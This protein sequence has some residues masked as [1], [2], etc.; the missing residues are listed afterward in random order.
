M[1]DRIY[2][3]TSHGRNKDGK[4]RPNRYAFFATDIV[5]IDSGDVTIKPVGRVYRRLAYDL[6]YNPV[7]QA[8]E[9]G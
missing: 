8:I 3:I 4:E 6:M 1:G 5:K 7:L 9:A 2:W